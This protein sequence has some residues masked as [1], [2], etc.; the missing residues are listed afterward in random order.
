M[1]AKNLHYGFVFC[2]AF[3]ECLI[4]QNTAGKVFSIEKVEDEMLRYEN[5]RFVLDLQR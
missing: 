2:P 1:Q 4:A 3:W 5:V